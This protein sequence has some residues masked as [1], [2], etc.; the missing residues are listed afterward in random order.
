MASILNSATTLV[1]DA[2]TSVSTSIHDFASSLGLEFDTDPT[3]KL[4]L[5]NVLHDYATYDYIIGIGVLTKEDI[6]FPDKTYM[7]NIS[8]P[9]NEA[10]RLICKTAGSDPNNRVKTDYGKYDFFVDNL[11]IESII[12]LQ[13]VSVTNTTLISFTV[14]EPFSM[15]LFPMACQTAAGQAGHNNWT[16]A[17]FLLTLEFRGNDEI[18]LMRAI[19]TANRYIP[20]KIATIEMKV[21]H[22]GATYEVSG[23]A[24][25]DQGKN[26]KNSV[27]TTDISIKGSTIQEVLQSGEQSLQAVWN[28]RLADLKT[29]GAVEVADEI[30]ILFPTTIVSDD[31]SAGNS[32]NSSGATI[33]STTSAEAIY[34]KLGTKLSDKNKT[35]VQDPA[36]VN[37]IGKT[38]MG[39]GT[40]KKA[41]APFAKPN[42]V[43]NDKNKVDDPSKNNPKPTE[44][45]LKFRQDTDIPNAINQTILSSDF[46]YGTFD[47]TALS[48]E[49]YRTWWRI[50]IQ[51]FLKDAPE[52][53]G[54][55][56]RPKII[57]YRIIPYKAH[58]SVGMTGVNETPKGYDKMVAVKE[59]NYIYTGKNT[60]VVTFDITMNNSFFAMMVADAGKDNQ[61]IKTAE[62][63]GD[64]APKNDTITIPGSAPAT[65]TTPQNRAYVGLGSITD[66]FGGGGNDTTA[67]R[68]ARIFHDAVTRGWDMMNLDMKI[69]GDPYFIAQSG[70]GNYTSKQTQF[71]NLNIDSSVHWQGV[72]VVANINFRTPIDIQNDTGMYAFNGDMPTSP[73]MQYSGFFKITTITNT[74]KGG[75]FEQSL[76]GYRYPLQEGSTPSETKGAFNLDNLVKK[77]V[78]ALSDLLGIK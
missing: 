6:N 77:G 63:A 38:T 51:V 20:F 33:S 50:D 37:I 76:S 4:P 52:N 57:V 16:D 27:L 3:I 9:K 36:K 74:F 61:D 71:P 40:S 53:K 42:E 19:P 35:Q 32:E 31:S 48:P 23:Y 64:E 5:P 11:T 47:K 58:A 30:I 66:L 2:V 73:L 68:A 72:E 25:N 15:G 28:R 60:D 29:T 18:G 8:L 59:Y 17:P 56:V 54:T 7:K 13:D 22:T 70:T 75:K 44:G 21:N 14:T 65:A 41:D 62:H 26:V 67:T 39:Y 46:P 10:T 1:S 55:G 34:Q 69:I 49:G 24:W 43:Y 78:G 12:G 45:I